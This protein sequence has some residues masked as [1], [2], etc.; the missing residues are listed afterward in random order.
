MQY[1]RQIKHHTRPQHSTSAT[2]RC[3]VPIGAKKKEIEAQ[4]KELT[5]QGFITLQVDLNPAETHSP[6]PQIKWDTESVHTSK[7]FKDSYHQ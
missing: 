1:V 5:V 7:G 4:L 3:R 6:N 2:Q